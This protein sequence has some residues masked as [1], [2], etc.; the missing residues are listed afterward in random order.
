[1]KSFLQYLEEAYISPN[2]GAKYGQV[3]FLVGGAASGKSTAIR[4][5]IDSASYKTL[6]PDDVKDLMRRASEKG[7]KGFED[8]VGVDPHSPE[9]ASVY[10]KKMRDTKL[11]SRYSRRLTSDPTRSPEAYPNLLFDRTFSFAGEIEKIS[12]SLIRYGYKPENIHIV[13]VFTDVNIA[14]KRNRERSRTL[15]DDIIVQTAK[16]AKKNFID[17]LF[18]RMKA[19][20]VNGDFFMVVN[21]RVITIKKSGKRVDRSGD[22]AKKVARTLG[23]L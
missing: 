22:V 8:L 12:K 23:I 21:E 15:A 11:S 18:Q 20:P 3:I 9:G 13:Y 5:F 6:N 4:N 10:H 16:G 14:L 7:M 2:N 1:M 17:L 19:A